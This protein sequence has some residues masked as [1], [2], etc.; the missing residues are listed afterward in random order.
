MFDWEAE[1]VLLGSV[2]N[3]PAELPSEASQLFGDNLLPFVVP[4]AHSD[5]T[6]PF[7][8]QSEDMGT[9]LHQAAITN[10]GEL[11]PRFAYIAKLREE[12][13][14]DAAAEVLAD[15]SGAETAPSDAGVVQPP[16]TRRG[17][18]K[19]RVLLLGSG[20]V[21]GSFVHQLA[22]LCGDRV[23]LTVASADV[24]AA[25]ALARTYAGA[26]ATGLSLPNEADAAAGASHADL[27]TLVGEHDV[28]V[29]LLPASLHGAVGGACLATGRHLVTSSYM[30]PALE[31]LGAD[32]T[33]AGLTMLHECGLDP[34]IDHFKAVDL[35][36][37]ARGSLQEV[38]GFESW[39]GGLPAP[40][41]AGPDALR[42]KFSW[43]PRGV[44]VASQASAR[45]REHG[46]IV[47]VPVGG[48]RGAARDVPLGALA[49]QGTPNRDSVAYEDIYG[50]GGPALRTM[51]RG[52][53]R[54][55]G[56]WQA[57]GQLEDVGLLRAEL[58]GANAPAQEGEECSLAALVAASAAAA[59]VNANAETRRAA[60]SVLR[61][62]FPAHG[63]AVAT[64]RIA[65]TPMD[66][67]A[68]VLEA[69]LAYG[70]GE[71]DMVALTHRVTMGNGKAHVAE[72]VCFGQPGG[73]S[74][75][76]H[77]VGAPAALATDYVLQGLVPAGAIRPV[78]PALCRRFLADLETRMG[79][80][81]REYDE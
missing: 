58:W 71:A 33:A 27:C 12:K 15:G 30:S 47:D 67:L 16:P 18:G 29:S 66:T 24:P 4:L 39:C 22:R 17:Q 49:L 62:C 40:Y 50:I 76:A 63:N 75:M 5:G 8:Q 43:S 36:E 72:L 69:G 35:F 53:L 46:E 32:A 54:Y 20:L 25:E 7:E 31:A 81:F 68:G 38:V 73:T 1:G 74:A 55:D 6:L 57:L 77:T 79:I 65:A 51:L 42:Y 59:G 37:R 14:A 80:A 19:R 61:S 45:F 3:L 56:F 78:D 64:A 60:E 26:R 41:C 44:L 21:A 13:E 52:T 48:L 28:V 2:D 34:G 23:A 10:H 11:T 9:V 70:P